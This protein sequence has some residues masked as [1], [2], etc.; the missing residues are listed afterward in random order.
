MITITQY[1][2]QLRLTLPVM[3]LLSFSLSSKAQR[4]VNGFNTN[5]GD[6]SDPVSITLTDGFRSSPIG[7][8]SVRIH[9]VNADYQFLTT[10]PSA[11]QNY[12]ISYTPRKSGITNPD[13]PA[14]ITRDVMVSIKYMDGL[15]R[16]LQ[17]V[18]VKASPY[19]RDIVQPLVYDA[20]GREAVKY[21]PYTLPATVISDG[22]YKTTAIAD[23]MAFY[24]P[25]GSSGTQ[26]STGVARITTP[27]AETRFEPSAF[28][29]PLEQGAPGDPWQLTGT[30][31]LTATP[32]H[33]IKK[34]YDVNVTNEVAYWT[35]NSSGGAATS[36]AY[37]PNQLDKTI[38]KDENWISGK[39]GTSEEFKD[40]QGRIVLKRIWKDE[41]TCLNTYYVYD[42]V[43]NLAYVI[44][45]AVTTT[46]FTEAPTDAE[47]NNYIYAY[48]S[49][50][51]NRVAEK[52]IP[53]KGWEHLAYNYIGQVV[54]TQDAMQRAN[55]KWTFTKYDGRGRV[56]MTGEITDNRTHQQITDA[57]IN[58]T[59]NWETPDNAFA[60][61]YTTSNSFPTSWNLLY[62]VKFY[63]DYTFPGNATFAP[64]ATGITIDA[65]GLLT[66]SKT[67]I[68][69]TGQMLL[70]ENYYDAEG[71]LRESISQNNIGGNDRVVNDYNFTSQLV[72]SIRTHNSSSIASLVIK[73]QYRY[74]HLGRKTHTLQQTG[75]TQPMVVVSKSDYNELGQLMS[76]RLHGVITGTDTLYLQ[77]INYTYNDRAWLSSSTAPLFAEQLR[78]NDASNGITSQ[79]NGNIANQYWG[80]Q[81]N[82]TKRYDY[83]YDALDRLTKGVSTTGHSETGQSGGDIDYDAMGNIQ[84][85][86]R[87]DPTSGTGNYTY[88]YTGNQ[89]QT[90]SG[91]TASTYH[92]D[93]NG[94]ADHDGRTGRDIGYNYLN[95][96]QTINSGANTITYTYT[97][98]GK[99]LKRA[100]SQAGNTDYDDGI[101]Y[102]NGGVY[103]ITEEGRV[104]KSGNAFNNY[105]YSLTD[106]LGN[107]RVTFDSSLGY[108]RL[109]QSNDYHPFGME[110][111]SNVTG[112]PKNEY[113]YNKKELQEELGQYDYGARFY[114]PVIGRWTS[115]DPLTEKN[116]RWSPYN[117]VQ[118]NPIRLIDPDGA[119]PIDITL[120][121]FAPFNWFGG[122]FKGDGENRRFSVDPNAKSKLNAMVRVETDNNSIISTRGGA[123]ISKGGFGLW[124]ARSPTEVQATMSGNTLAMSSQAGN[125]AAIPFFDTKIGTWTNEDIDNNAKLHFAIFNGEK[126]NQI[127]RISGEITGDH[128]PAGEA[129]ATD[130]KGNSVFLGASDAGPWSH[131][132][133]FAPYFGLAG[134]GDQVMSV[135]NVSINVNKDGTFNSVVGSDGKTIS[136][137]DW[138]KKFEQKPT[139][140][141]SQTVGMTIK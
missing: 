9:I 3:I 2:R 67:R 13:D 129:F 91:L 101:I 48:H 57:L 11:N 72:Q 16:A 38:E 78:Y 100:S 32:G 81:G 26:L 84:H 135:V 139:V 39:A 43:G 137:S 132:S 59:I 111:T 97:A 54:A 136:I 108:A 56:I 88:N 25:N 93:N 73:N 105:E 127:L 53:G 30:A 24:N 46:S 75:T 74:D 68:L 85:L 103:I 19:G 71:R 124:S 34:T 17:N 98:D 28:N 5:H 130:A 69:T 15:G 41:S 6:I 115:V 77:E 92:Y 20:F 35:T 22:S 65:T 125:H 96:P 44:P 55:N 60:D 52:K 66:G 62:T 123:T 33:T 21:L 109:V 51:R 113:L 106:H 76:K 133:T 80:I 104:L 128:F 63:D 4:T 134:H 141:Y 8:Q 110:H 126:G 61:G 12:I 29:R 87:V 64:T 10:A 47:F 49:D 107:S 86:K 99:K 138:N 118:G 116:R 40:K 140:P 7:M 31:G 119:F 79:F 58:Q 45:P 42:D 117:Y 83:S 120:R 121:S 95:L 37:Q 1:S 36:A 82:V 18:Q 70:T 27:Y 102:D 131:N 114:D 90:V 122:G 112:S 23:Q 89:L 14:N 94:N 50:N